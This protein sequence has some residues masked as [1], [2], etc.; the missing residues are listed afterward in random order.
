MTPGQMAITWRQL[1]PMTKFPLYPTVSAVV[2]WAQLLF[3]YLRIGKRRHH[4]VIKNIVPTG[5]TWKPFGLIRGLL[6]RVG[7]LRVSPQPKGKFMATLRSRLIKALTSKKLGNALA[8]ASIAAQLRSLR[9]RHQTA[10]AR[11]RRQPRRPTSTPFRRDR[12]EA[13]RHHRRRRSDSPLID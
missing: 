13:E 11:H 7:G 6:K 12:G 2:P 9:S 4:T 8:D 10:R 5:A 3:G 1:L